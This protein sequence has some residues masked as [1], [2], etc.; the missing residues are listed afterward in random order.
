MA[1]APGRNYE[2]TRGENRLR[3][4]PEE[5]AWV[6]RGLD[7][8]MPCTSTDCGGRGEGS[9]PGNHEEFSALV[10]AGHG[11]AAKEAHNPIALA[12]AARVDHRRNI[13]KHTAP[14]L[15]C[16]HLTYRGDCCNSSGISTFS[17]CICIAREK[18]RNLIRFKQGSGQAARLGE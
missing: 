2:S 17:R 6:A 3:V 13:K 14:I 16:L 4:T 12:L 15:D 1:R 10:A 18:T 7:C 8:M 9:Y 5:K 11:S